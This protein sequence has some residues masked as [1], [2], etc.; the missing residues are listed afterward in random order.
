MGEETQR[1][2]HEVSAPLFSPAFIN[3]QNKSLGVP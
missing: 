1:G 2:G 3:C